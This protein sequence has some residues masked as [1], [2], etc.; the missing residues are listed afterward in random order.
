MKSGRLGEKEGLPSQRLII[1]EINVE[2]ECE[3]IYDC[4]ISGLTW[5]L[6]EL[7]CD[8]QNGGASK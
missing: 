2:N 4:V 1:K 7:T 3:V 6:E 5:I 8:G